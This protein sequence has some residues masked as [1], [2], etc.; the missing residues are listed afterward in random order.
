MR[1]ARFRLD[2][3]YLFAHRGHHIAEHPIDHEVA[4]IPPP[5]RTA[6][7]IS[8]PSFMP[9][10]DLV[11]LLSVWWKQRVAHRVLSLP[12]VELWHGVWDSDQ[13]RHPYRC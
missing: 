10:D 1:L 4:A 6:D 13:G 7:R 2:D 3:L 8:R 12:S 11:K 9:V 5:P